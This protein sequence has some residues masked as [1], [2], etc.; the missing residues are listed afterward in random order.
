MKVRTHNLGFPRIGPRRELKKALEAYWSGKGTEAELLAT[1][2]AIREQNWHLQKAA[3]IDLIPSNDFS[4]Y[5]QVLDTSA[6]VGAV[7]ARFHWQGDTVPL[8]TYFEMARG[9]GSEPP[10]EMTKWFDTNYHYLVPELHP[11]QAFCLAST[12]PLDEFTEAKALGVETVPVLLGP[13]SFLLLGKARDERGHEFNPLVLLPGLLPVYES[14]LQQLSR[15]GARWVQLDE[16]ALALDL[17]TETLAFFGPAYARLRAAASPAQLMLATYFGELGANRATALRLPVDA[18]HI[19]AVRARHEAGAVLEGVPSGM[20]LSLGI[21]D[22]R[23][24]WRNDYAASLELLRRA[25]QTIGADRLMVSPS[26]SLLHVPVSVNGESQLDRALKGWLAFAEQKLEEVGTLAG[27]LEG[28]ADEAK[29]SENQTLIEGRRLSPRSH[30]PNVK[31]RCARVTDA[32]TRRAAA[33]AVRARIHPTSLRLPQLPTTTIGSFPQ[34]ET[35]RAARARYKRGEWSLAQYEHFLEEE[36][37]SCIRHQEELGLDVLV[38]GEFER[39][40][41]VEYFGEQLAG[42]AFSQNGWVQSYGSRCVKPPILFGDVRRPQPMTVRWAKFAQGLT[43]KP[44]KGM[45][46]GPLTILQWSFVRD[47]QPRSETAR[48]LA[49]AIRDEVLD[50]EAAGIRIIQIDE[51]ALREGLPLR[52]ADRAAYLEWAAAAFRLAAGG[53]KDATQIHT[54]M[55]YSE[56]KDI[57]HA[58]AALDADVISFETSRSGMDLLQT[59]ADFR[60]PAAIGPGIWDIHSPRVP[61]TSEMVQRLQAALRVIPK[62]RLWVNPDCGLKTRRWEEVIPALRNLVAAAKAVRAADPGPATTRGDSPLRLAESMT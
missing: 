49:L 22:G 44:V 7:P 9:T 54:H 5:D 34:T 55:C 17:P 33:C 45:L 19:D 26:C 61:T 6:L 27:L 31:A 14:L 12:K 40:D 53:V 62:E 39:N 13:I 32:D 16:P 41:M 21:V 59:F 8:S 46:T 3:G 18:V 50:L 43:R 37:R 28:E 51:P 1:A 56:F 58:I 35:V 4:L 10:L 23:N 52:R 57:L 47:D 25:K 11:G 29:L 60:Y 48:Q 30:D 38:H 42:F 2:K 15:L 36:I 24:I 20:A